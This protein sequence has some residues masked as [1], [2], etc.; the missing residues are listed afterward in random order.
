MRSYLY[1][2]KVMLGWS[3]LILLNNKCPNVLCNKIKT[4]RRN[5]LRYPMLYIVTCVQTNNTHMF[6]NIGLYIQT[7]TGIS[8][9]MNAL[10]KMQ[11]LYSLMPNI[12]SVLHHHTRIVNTLWRSNISI[13]FP[14]AILLRWNVLERYIQDTYRQVF[15][16]A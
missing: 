16:S 6:V 10:F 1:A 13:I 12:V 9:C 14:S 4:L 3:L 11:Y 7:Q 8:A 5:I 15:A 2:T